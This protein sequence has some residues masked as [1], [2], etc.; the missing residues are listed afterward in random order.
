MDYKHLRFTIHERTIHHG[1][2]F[3]KV[4]V[5]SPCDRKSIPF[6]KLC[7]RVSK[8][9]T[10]SP[11]EVKAVF[12]QA[13]DDLKEILRGGGSVDLGEFG[14]FSVS[15]KSKAIKKIEE[16]S[17]RQHIEGAYIRF[18]PSD[19]FVDLSTIQLQ[20]VEKGAFK[21]KKQQSAGGGSASSGGTSHTGDSGGEDGSDSV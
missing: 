16:F 8:S 19:R 2:S 21:L 15:I 4:Y 20:R 11:Y 13:V 6:S 18:I 14:K 3:K 1:S 9:C 12:Q 7:Q 5:A 17:I 10:F